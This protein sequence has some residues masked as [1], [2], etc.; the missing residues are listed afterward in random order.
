MQRIGV[1]TSGGDAP[2]MNAAVRAVT[3]QALNLEMEVMG[4]SRGYSG[5]IKGEITELTDKDVSGR[6]NRGGTFLFTARS[7]KFKTAVG[8]EE[9]IS[10]LKRFG[11]E[12]LV[13]IGG[14]GSLQGARELEKGGVPTVGVPASIDNDLPGTD[15]SIG[16]DTAVNTVVEAVDKIR[17][18]ATSHERVFVV[19][20]MG[21]N[22]GLLTLESGL[23]VGAEA[24]LIP[25]I[26]FDIKEVCQIVKQGY[27]SGKSHNLILVA[28]GI[29][30]C[31]LD[32]PD[33]KDEHYSAAFQIGDMISQN[34]G[35]EVRIIV[36]G[37]VQRGGAPSAIDRV[38]AS[39]MGAEAVKVLISGE[40]GVMIGISRDELIAVDYDVILEKEKKI[41]TSLYELAKILG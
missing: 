30:D 15:Y 40:S 25:E 2:G 26:D 41:D 12:G 20:T 10:Q 5:L 38:T 27:E 24:I 17:D 19:E 36:L 31:C 16:F 3:R 7:E 21:R 9:A 1:M 39:R 8:Q 35:Y 29:Q 28:E 18:T 32:Q 11:I 6:I 4:I 34:T 14:D 13:V 37:H 33:K 22:N 23:A